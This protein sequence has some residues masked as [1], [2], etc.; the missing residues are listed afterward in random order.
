MSLPP[1]HVPS[2]CKNVCQMDPGSGLC[3]GCRRTL[4][5]IAEWLEMTA[6]EKLATLE[7]V[8]QRIR[9]LGET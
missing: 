5:E 9:V 2:P 7:R 3:L 4:R 1:I 6:E 8:E